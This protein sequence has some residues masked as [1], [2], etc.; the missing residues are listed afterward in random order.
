[1]PSQSPSVCLLSNPG[2]EQ[3]KETVAKCEILQQPR[4]YTK[5]TYSNHNS[6]H[7]SINIC[8]QCDTAGTKH[9]Y[10]HAESLE[11]PFCNAAFFSHT[12]LP[13]GGRQPFRLSP[14]RTPLFSSS[15]SRA[16]FGWFLSLIMTPAFSR[17]HRLHSRLTCSAS[18]RTR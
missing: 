16:R 11:Y 18:C 7:S 12:N 9:V 6:P 8:E 17:L 15:P 5:N 2:V 4:C 13:A 14:H 3:K 1:M 10:W